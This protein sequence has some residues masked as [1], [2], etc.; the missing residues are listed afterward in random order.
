[1]GVFAGNQAWDGIVDVFPFGALNGWCTG[2]GDESNSSG[3]VPTEHWSSVYFASPV[4]VG[5]WRVHSHADRDGSPAG[6]DANPHYLYLQYSLDGTTWYKHSRVLLDGANA[7]NDRYY[8][9]D[10]ADNDHSVAEGP[11]IASGGGGGGGGGG[12]GDPATGTGQTGTGATTSGTLTGTFLDCTA[13]GRFGIDDAGIISRVAFRT[14]DDETSLV[15]G[16]DVKHATSG[17]DGFKGFGNKQP[18]WSVGATASS[19]Y[20]S[21]SGILTLE[22][23]GGY[24]SSDDATITLRGPGT[25]YTTHL[26]LN[27]PADYVSVSSSGDDWTDVGIVVKRRKEFVVHTTSR[28]WA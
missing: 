15:G 5:S 4:T 7:N 12:S 23:R 16:T 28:L 14:G 6:D 25:L 27:A 17:T 10:Q 26:D 1:M 18:S 22:K 19:S 3:V 20:N 11:G 2:T 24:A 21:S 9:K 8:W 13:G